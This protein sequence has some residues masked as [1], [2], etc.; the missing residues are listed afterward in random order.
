MYQISAL[1]NVGGLQDDPKDNRGAATPNTE[2]VETAISGEHVHARGAS[3][4]CMH[5]ATAGEADGSGEN[6][7]STR[8]EN[9]Q[10]LAA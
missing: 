5:A 3:Q 1:V 2:K 7:K 10:E 6:V 9:E 8:S 4:L